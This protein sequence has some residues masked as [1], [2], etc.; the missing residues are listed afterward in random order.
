MRFRNYGIIGGV[1]LEIYRRM[2]LVRDL[3]RCY[4][5]QVLLFRFDA[6]IVLVEM[7]NEGGYER[8]LRPMW[9]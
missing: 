2:T 5:Q 3:L 6:V 7:Q 9:E 1:C 4:S 8:G